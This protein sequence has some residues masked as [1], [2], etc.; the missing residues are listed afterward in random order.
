M[1]KELINKKIL[2]S[3]SIDNKLIIQVNKNTIYTVNDSVHIIT[4]ND[5]KL[6]DGYYRYA[7]N[8]FVKIADSTSSNY[9]SLLTLCTLSNNRLTRA[10]MPSSLAKF[11]KF[12]SKLN[13]GV[14]YTSMR[15]PLERESVRFALRITADDQYCIISD[16]F[17]EVDEN[18]NV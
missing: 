7:N 11:A 15:S 8:T 18:E 1:F 14:E 9:G 10:R 5:Y 2:K 16:F 6:A 3:N 4:S 12:A 13:Y 17:D